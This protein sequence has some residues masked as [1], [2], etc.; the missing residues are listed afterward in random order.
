LDE[1]DRGR[2]NAQRGLRIAYGEQIPRLE[3]GMTVRAF[4]QRG[5]G[6]FEAL[7]ERIRQLEK[8]LAARPEDAALLA[9]YGELQGAFEAGG[10]YERTHVCERVLDGIGFAG[11]DQDKDVTVLSGGEKSRLVL[12]SLMTAPA[13]LL[14]L[15]E[16]TN[17]LDLEGIE[18]LEN[19]LAR[20]PGA[21]VIVSHDRSFLDNV[22][23][24]IVE[25]EGGQAR[26]YKGNYAAFCKQREANDL[27]M[28]RAFKTQ[29]EFI[30]KEMDYIRRNMAGR[31]H[32]QAKGR[33]KRLQRL[34]RIQR[35][36]GAKAKMVLRLQGGRGLAGQALIE[37]EDLAAR[38]PDGRELFAGARL[39]L[40]YGEVVGLLGRNGAG[41]TTLLRM[42][43]G[44]Q[45]PAGGTV[46]RAHAVQHA[47]FAQEMHDLPQ[48]GAVLDALRAVDPTA[49]DQEL[50]DHLGLFLFRGDDGLAPVATLSGGEKR[51]LALARLL[52]APFDLLCLDEPTNHLD[53]SSREALEEALAAYPGA[54]LVISSTPG[55]CACSRAVW[56]MRSRRCTPNA[57]SSALPPP[58]TSASAPLP[59]APSR[60]RR[61]SPVGSATR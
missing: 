43:I 13:D 16:P 11:S 58:R 1:P 24:S 31:M 9:T 49:T 14:V 29:Q 8:Q 12:C 45:V 39:R 33:L 50:R 53:I 4:V 25:L 3:P 22:A 30:D 38:T 59:N 51:R 40:E 61:P 15:D 41:K 32:A 18:F 17:H 28:A 56:P 52:R 42:L 21:V 46:H 26:R 6:T 47:Y 7:A 2:R 27:A 37:A 35:P 10:G 57:S 55:A 44:Q 5:D 48:Q 34:E 20:W 54:A 36:R 60:A 19:H 23:T